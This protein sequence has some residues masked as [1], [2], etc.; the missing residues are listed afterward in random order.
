ML[1]YE[2]ARVGWG[3]DAPRT[4]PAR[5][6]I[7]QENVVFSIVRQ[8]GPLLL[9]VGQKLLVISG[10]SKSEVLGSAYVVA[11]HAQERSQPEGDIV[12]EVEASHQ[13]G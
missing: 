12:I 7:V 4:R 10:L 8:K 13:S 1:Q 6:G 9:G 2:D 3:R 11:H 5:P